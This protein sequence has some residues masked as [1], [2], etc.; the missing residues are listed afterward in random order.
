MILD[1]S[2]EIQRNSSKNVSVDFEYSTVDNLYF[3]IR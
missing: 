1:I 2:N 3:E